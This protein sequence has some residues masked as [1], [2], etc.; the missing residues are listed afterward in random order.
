METFGDNADPALVLIHGGGNTMLS[1]HDDLCERLAAGGRFVVRY[2]QRG[3]GYPELVAECVALLDTRGLARAH[4][5]GIS[6]GAA[7][8]QLMALDHPDR[9]ATLTLAS[10]TPGGP[11]HPAPDLPGPSRALPWPPDPDWGDRAAVIDFLVEAE[12]PYAHSFDERTA[13]EIAARV[14]DHR[15]DLEAY[16]TDTAEFDVGEPWRQRLGEIT[17]PTLVVHGTE[18]PLFPLAHGEALAREIPGAELLALEHTGHEYFP[19]AT[20]EVVVPALLAHSSRS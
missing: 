12:R 5:V 10:A 13:R 20:W 7:I 14:V 9:V 3:S 19:R 1:W 15:P 18:D 11:A 8:A 16:M 6:L 4:L 17:A 2:D